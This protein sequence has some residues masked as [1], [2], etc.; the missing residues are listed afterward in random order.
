MLLM[1]GLRRMEAL[2]LPHARL[3][4][5]ARGIRL[6]DTKGGAQVRPIGAA[7]A[8]AEMGYPELAIADLLGHRRSG[9]ALR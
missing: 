6:E 8:S 9:V 4:T 1:P 2:A 3:D 7:A 5:K